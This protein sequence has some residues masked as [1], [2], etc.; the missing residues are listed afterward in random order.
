MVCEELVCKWQFIRKIIA[1][2]EADTRFLSWKYSISAQQ[3]QITWFLAFNLQC[4]KCGIL[5]N[6]L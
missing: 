6:E 1:G 3:G 5:F 2:S 4:L